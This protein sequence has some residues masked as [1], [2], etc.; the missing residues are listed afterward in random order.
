MRSEV[1]REN[2]DWELQWDRE[3][4]AVRPSERYAHV[5]AEVC[6]VYG[7]SPIIIYRRR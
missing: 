4:V 3:N 7:V 1:E 2:V 6:V 5:C